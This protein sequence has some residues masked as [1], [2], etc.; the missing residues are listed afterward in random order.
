[1]DVRAFRAAPA[2]SR[3]IFYQLGPG[4]NLKNS[5]RQI[6]LICFAPE[7]KP[8]I[9]MRFP[10]RLWFG[11]RMVIFLR[12]YV[13]I[14]VCHTITFEI[15]DLRGSFLVR[16]YNF[17]NY[18]LNSRSRPPVYQGRRVSVKVIGANKARTRMVRL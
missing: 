16:R 2:F 8:K 1:L 15:P 18:T 10:R 5:I 17:Q 7:R 13:C 3:P 14:S 12:A 11:H 4:W 9:S 6:H